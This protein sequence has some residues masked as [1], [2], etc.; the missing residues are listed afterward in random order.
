MVKHYKLISGSGKPG[1]LKKASIACAAMP[2]MQLRMVISYYI[3]W[4]YRKLTLVMLLFHAISAVHHFL[5][6]AKDLL[7]GR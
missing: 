3:I 5:I 7:A 6:F 1:S 2:L 4:I